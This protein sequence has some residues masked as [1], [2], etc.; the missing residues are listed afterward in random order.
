MNVEKTNLAVHDKFPDTFIG[1]SVV[2]SSRLRVLDQISLF[3]QSGKFLLG[4]RLVTVRVGLCR[5]CKMKKFR[6]IY[7]GRLPGNR[8]VHHIQ[9]IFQNRSSTAKSLDHNFN[10][11]S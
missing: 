4:A 5:V 3:Y 2:M 8:L 10:L 1:R 11:D 6:I 7:K 9:A